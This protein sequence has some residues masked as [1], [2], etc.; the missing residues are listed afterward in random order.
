MRAVAIF[1]ALLGAACN[2]RGPTAPTP[3]P[4]VVVPPP[5]VVTPPP[6]FP[7]DDS[8][9]SMTFYRQLVHNAFDSPRSLEP[10]RRKSVAQSIFVMTVDDAGAP[11]DAR[12]L[13]ATAAALINTAAQLT[14]SFGLAGLTM[15]AL[16]PPFHPDQIT[17]TWK[18]QPTT[19]CGAAVVTGTTIALAPKTPNCSC[20][21][22]AIRPVVVKHEFGH[23]L[24]FHHTD[25]PTDLMHG[26][27]GACDKEPS[28]RERY[29][30]AVAYS[31]PVGSVAP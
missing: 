17:V 12:T 14:G 5:V 28:E 30:A 1:V 23:I 20:G 2:G 15:G 18:S 13:D 26:G 10:L 6:A 21:A 7:P 16:E 25:A 27:S 31:R 19:Y 22:L 9:F 3:P 8:R 24:G 4:V 11:I 29:H